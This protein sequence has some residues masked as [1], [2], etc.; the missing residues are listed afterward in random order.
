MSNFEYRVIK[1]TYGS[2]QSQFDIERIIP[3]NQP[4]NPLA[5][6]ILLWLVSP[7]AYPLFRIFGSDGSW[8]RCKSYME[9]NEALLYIA[10]RKKEDAYSKVVKREKIQLW[11]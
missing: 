10:Q 11:K 7:I 6:K 4:C 5:L 9:L 2:G 1:K 8:E 3:Y